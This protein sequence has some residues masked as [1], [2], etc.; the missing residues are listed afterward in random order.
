M[1]SN[2]DTNFTP[3]KVGFS[4]GSHAAAALHLCLRK[5]LHPQTYTET[6][7][8]YKEEIELP[9]TQEKFF[10]ECKLLQPKDNSLAA[11]YSVKGSNDDEDVTQGAKIKCYLFAERP[12]RHISYYQEAPHILQAQDWSLK[13]HAGKGLGVATLNG[14]RVSKG[15]P[16]INQ[17]PL[18]MLQKIFSSW[19]AENKNYIDRKSHS[20]NI[21]KAYH[22]LFEVEEGESI[23]E[24]TMNK[25]VGVLG[26]I[27]FLGSSGL[28]KP[29]STKAY[30]QSIA[31]EVS[32]AQNTNAKE[33]YFILGN[34]ALRYVREY[35]K[36][37]A[38][39]IIETGN[40]VYDS[41]AMIKKKIADK[42]FFVSG[43]G[44]MTHLAL[45]H[46]NTHSRYGR[47]DIQ[48]ILTWLKTDCLNA[49]DEE[50]FYRLQNL[51]KKSE[52]IALNSMRDLDE[53]LLQ[54]DNMM[55]QLL[56]Q[57]V[58]KRALHV[59]QEWKIELKKN[60][61]IGLYLINSHAQTFFLQEDNAAKSGEQ[62][63]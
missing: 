56:Y 17:G 47:I 48:K 37:E 22:A 49:F 61:D 55:A 54:T 25:K 14:L 3:L 41:L 12:Y 1:L 60:F 39:Q 7:T 16:A 28:V 20:K 29:L 30:L 59:M 63:N 51:E 57:T 10:L 44:K 6:N 46:K 42:V 31:A 8:N 21:K 34:N 43:L 32:V 35:L 50:N 62:K 13:V 18:Q 9:N 2:I 38:V 5:L 36:V 26:G 23:A 53:K 4:T 19:V 52:F 33:I 45:G 11:A 40:Y 24:K 58:L 15:F 27:S